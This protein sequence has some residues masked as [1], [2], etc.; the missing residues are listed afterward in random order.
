MQITAQM[1]ESAV[2]AL[3]KM[4]DALVEA[5]RDGGADGIPESYLHLALLQLNAPPSL[6]KQIVDTLIQGGVFRRRHDRIYL[7]EVA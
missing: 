5:V 4:R 1:T 7:A 2:R 6:P 3:V